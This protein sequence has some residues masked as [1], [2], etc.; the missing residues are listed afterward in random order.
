MR[1]NVAIFS[2]EILRILGNKIVLKYAK[3]INVVVFVKY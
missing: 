2:L 3:N 1:Y